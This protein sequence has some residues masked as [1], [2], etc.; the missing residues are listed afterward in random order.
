MGCLNRPRAA[1]QFRKKSAQ[2]PG[3]TCLPS[4]AAH[5]QPA[6][7]RGRA[8][9][10]RAGGSGGSTRCPSPAVPAAQRQHIQRPWPTIGQLSAR[11]PTWRGAA[12]AGTEIIGAVGAPPLRY[13][14]LGCSRQSR[15]GVRAVIV[16]A[17]CHR[18]GPGSWTQPAR[19]AGS[20]H[21]D[22]RTPARPDGCAPGNMQLPRRGW[23]GRCQ[24]RP[25]RS[26]DLWAPGRGR[27]DWPAL[28]AADDVR[29]ARS[30]ATAA[31]LA[32]RR[33]CH[34]GAA[35]RRSSDRGRGRHG[36]S[37]PRCDCRHAPAPRPGNAHRYRPAPRAVPRTRHR[38]RR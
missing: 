12:H 30:S 3:S 5:L 31:V 20:R 22:G 13:A 19:P 26:A 34:C 7:R 4:I 35:A 15:A 38:H 29:R 36:S 37:P 14:D 24:R 23:L 25:S 21:R 1:F 28:A 11:P 27:P 10:A 32:V 6:R 18:L 2:R 8:R 17:R 16:R 33:S 9:S